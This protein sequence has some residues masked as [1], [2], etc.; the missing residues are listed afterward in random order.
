MGIDDNSGP[1]GISV[2][3]GWVGTNDSTFSPSTIKP[4]DDSSVSS[5]PPYLIAGC[6]AGGGGGEPG[7]CDGV[8]CGAPVPESPGTECCPSPI[9]ID[10]AGNGFN[11]TDA[12]GGVSFDLNR[13]GVAEHL[14]WTSA[15]SDDAF[16][17]LDRNGNGAIDNGAELFG[18]YTP[19]PASPT[20]N[21][22]I[23]LAEFDKPALGGNGDGR[24]NRDDAIFSSLRLWQDTN[25]NGVSEAGEI[26]RLRSLGLAAIDL[27]YRQSRRTDQFGNQ[28]LYRARIRDAQGANLGGWAW[29]VFFVKL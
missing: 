19:Q 8:I 3:N 4:C 16:L 10:V 14:S 26:H 11:L 21:G 23:A 6:Y 22:F 15:G 12:A 27:D 13:D 20:P 9:L 1:S 17:A 18:N 2:M 7:P 25:H 29:D 5:E 24:I 28:F